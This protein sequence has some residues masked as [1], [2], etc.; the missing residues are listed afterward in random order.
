MQ[1]KHDLPQPTQPPARIHG[2]ASRPTAAELAA[3]RAPFESAR[4]LP[5]ACYTSD[6]VFR[7]E[8]AELF[9]R[10]W[11]CVGRA[12]DL[13]NAGDFFTLDVG[14]ERILVVRGGDATLRA[15]FNVCRHR[16]SRIVDEPCGEGLERLRCP[17]H[18]WTYALDGR[19]THAPRMGASFARD[20]FSL[21]PL[22]LGVFWG[23]LFV[24]LDDRA[25]PLERAMADLPDLSRYQM[26]ELRRGR[27]VEYEVAANW[28]FLCENYS[29]CYHCPG[30]HPQLFRISDYLEPGARQLESGACFNG[31][32]MALRAG[33]STMS[34]SG[35]SQ[36]PQIP[37][38]SAEDHRQ[39]LYYLVYPNLLLSPHP[40]YVL[41]HTIWPQ[42]PARSR[43]VCEWLFTPEAVAEKGFDPVDVVEFWDLTNRQDWGLCERAQ[44]GASS[45]G[46][47]QGPYQSTEDC[48][49]TF[50]R[51]Y[52]DKLAPL[53]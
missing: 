41:T 6:E 49:Y 24:N 1:A 50:D 8:Q 48:V 5:A 27:R 35:R 17:Y 21:V 23:F 39:V 37:G 44:A 15:F 36:L 42:G 43:V 13:P 53:L 25:E 19:L 16:G 26:G 38:L 32:A 11:L 52:A 10:M 46:Y 2:G 40:D 34:M 18:A 33:F 14:A 22:R 9:G 20:P 47:R 29:E 7:L 4:T 12:A 45:R 31:G 28:K 3:T 51:W 30:V